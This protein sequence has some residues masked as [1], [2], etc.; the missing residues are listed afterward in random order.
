MAS[1][2][3]KTHINIPIFSAVVQDVKQQVTYTTTTSSFFCT[4]S[5]KNVK[6]IVQTNPFTLYRHRATRELGGGG[7]GISP[8]CSER[9]WNTLIRCSQGME[10]LPSGVQRFMI[11]LTTYICLRPKLRKPGN[12]IPCPLYAISGQPLIN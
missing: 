6:V 3:I 11:Q 5:D 9:C 4:L 10:V 7:G 8:L 2:S 1:H 12:T